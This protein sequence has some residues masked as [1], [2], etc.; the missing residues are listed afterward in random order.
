MPLSKWSHETG[1]N[2]IVR[3]A[4]GSSPL[5]Q[6][7]TAFLPACNQPLQNLLMHP[8]SAV[9]LCLLNP[10]EAAAAEV[11]AAEAAAAA[12]AAQAAALAPSKQLAAA[13]TLRGYKLTLPEVKVG[14][15]K[16]YVDGVDG[17]V[18]WPV[19]LMYPETGQQDVIEDWHEEDPVEAHLDVVSGQ[20]LGFRVWALDPWFKQLEKEFSCVKW[21]AETQAGRKEVEGRQ[22]RRAVLY[23]HVE[24]SVAAR[25]KQRRTDVR[26]HA[27]FSSLPE[28]SACVSSHSLSTCLHAVSLLLL[29][30]ACLS[31]GC[32]CLAL[33]P[34]PCRG[35]LTGSTTGTG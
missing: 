31:A 5:T 28:C 11:K 29:V 33:R 20:G 8:A 6:K 1:S 24:S 32:R 7:Y 19:L 34:L 4:A 21:V 15:R 35:T 14:T 10:Q 25:Q 18:H 2:C 3:V 26:L 16:P 9:L 30:P 22:T 17:S 27:L 23:L 13:L 12:A